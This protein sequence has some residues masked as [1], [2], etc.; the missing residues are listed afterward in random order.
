[1]SVARIVRA[2]LNDE[3]AILPVSSYLDGEYGINDLFTGVPS[4][5]PKRRPRNY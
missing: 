1:M 2:I 4:R 5:G 3:Q